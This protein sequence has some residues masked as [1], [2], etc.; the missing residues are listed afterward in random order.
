M[1]SKIF[2][3][4]PKIMSELGSVHKGRDAPAAAGG[5]K[6]RGIEDMYNAIHP[7]LVKNKVFCAPQVV[8]RTMESYEG[9]NK[10]G[11][12]KTSFRV[13][14]TVCH[15]FYAEDGSFVEVTTCGEGIDTSDKA[16]NKAMS[17]AMKYAFIELFS[18]PTKDVEDPE[19]TNEEIDTGQKQETQKAAPRQSFGPRTFGARQ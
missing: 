6:F 15:K 11:E 13:L 1:S 10:Q 5:Y 17:G 7:I 2:E 14:L 8:D 3:M 19:A 18:I 4:I 12:K 9:V 16:S